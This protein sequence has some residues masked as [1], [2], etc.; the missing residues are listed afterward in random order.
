M[1]SPVNI[2][3]ET[4]VARTSDMIASN[5]D[6]EVVMMSVSGGKYYGMDSIGSRVWEFLDRPRKVSELC[7]LLC[8]EFDVEPA[9]CGRD[10]LAFLRELAGKN[11]IEAVDARP[12]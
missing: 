9:Q 4:T 10:V 7:A 3:A 2:N 11:I 12:G 8:E 6:G 5:I 1:S